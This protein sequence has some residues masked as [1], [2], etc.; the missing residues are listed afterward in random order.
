MNLANFINLTNMELGLILVEASIIGLAF[1][2]LRYFRR[3]R[4]LLS[5]Q[6]KNPILSDRLM[7]LSRE[8]EA[9]CQS[10]ADNLEEKKEIAN[11]LMTRLDERIRTLQ[12]L[13]G[14][15]AE[16]SSLPQEKAKPLDAEICK[17]A[18]AGYEV[19]EIA[20]QLQLSK[21]EVQLTLD[22]KRFRQ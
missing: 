19:A 1:V 2:M 22:L 20:R 17:M 5:N 13:L 3:N 10:L 4:N 21:G 7:D 15:E 12:A 8:S 11:R 9:V 14:N 6:R 18:E 16:N